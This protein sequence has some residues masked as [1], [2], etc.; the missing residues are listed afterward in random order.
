M[1]YLDFKLGSRGGARW[2]GKLDG[3]A[4]ILDVLWLSGPEVWSLTI[5]DGKETL[6]RAGLWLRHGEDI[7]E[8]FTSPDLPGGGVGKLRVWDTANQQRDP[9]RD[10][11][12]R[13]SGVRLIYIPAAEVA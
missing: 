3:R 2:R 13:G 6:L 5:Y 1:E 11:L 8:A 7:L 12:R 9:G 4:Y 10:D